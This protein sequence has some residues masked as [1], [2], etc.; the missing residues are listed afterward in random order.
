MKSPDWYT[1]TAAMRVAPLAPCARRR[2]RRRTTT[3]TMGT[4]FSEDPDATLLRE[5]A[6]GN[7]EAFAGFYHKHAGRLFAIILA[8]VQDRSAA[9]DVAQEAFLQIW[10][11]ASQYNE[12]VANS[13]AWATTI[14]KNKAIDHVRAR[15]R[16]PVL[17]PEPELGSENAVPAPGEASDRATAQELATAVTQALSTLPAEQRQAIEMAFIA[18]MSQSEIAEALSTPLGTIKARI[19]RGMFRLRDDLHHFQSPPL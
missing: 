17:S 5:I 7:R 10:K 19:R 13:M 4:T 9:E 8:I 18:G 16:R 15:A 1:V 12:E 6:G 11:Q 2:N 3:P 14:A